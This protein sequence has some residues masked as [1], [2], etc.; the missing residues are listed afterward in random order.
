MI[1]RIIASLLLVLCVAASAWPKLKEDDQK[2][3]ED[4]FKTILD[5]VQAL[6]TQL[7]TLNAQ[8]QVLQQNQAQVQAIITRQ[9]RS[10]Q[11]LDQMVHSLAINNEENFS[12][13]KMVIL[14][15]RKETQDGL[16][17]LGG[18]SSSPVAGGGGTAPAPAPTQA[19]GLAYIIEAKEDNMEIDMGSSQ[20]LHPGSRL[21]FFKASD[22]NTP[23]GIVEVDQVLGAGRSRVKVVN[24]NPGVQVE[25]GDMVRLQ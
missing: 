17:K 16:A 1:R 20:G 11:D 15:L 22:P 3:F 8:L 2:F 7:Q 14:Q 13:V 23:V 5:Q 21:Q 18:M 9:Q 6:T 25:W 24:L 12:S 19:S 4:Q 10:L